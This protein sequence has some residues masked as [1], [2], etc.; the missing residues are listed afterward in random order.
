MFNLLKRFARF[1]ASLG[2]S[3]QIP[4]V[5]TDSY[6]ALLTTTL[7]NMQPRLHDN[8]TKG[9]KLIAWLEM[10]GRTRRVD[11]GERIQ[12]ALMHAQNS[13]ADIYSAYGTL[14]TTPQDG[15][16]AA[17]YEWAQLAVAISISRKEERQNSGQSRLLS[18][19]QSKTMQAEVSLKQLLNNCVVSG[20]I[21]S[22]VSGAS[23]RFSQRTG[24]LD[25]GALGPLPLPALVDVSPTRNVAIGN[26]NPSTYGFW[27]NQAVSSTATTFAGMKQEMNQTYNNASRGGGEGGGTGSPDLLIGD[28]RAWEQYWNSLQNQE[29]YIVDNPRVLNVLGGSEALKFR[30]GTFIWDE[31]VPD[32]ETNADLVDGIGTVTASTIYFLNTDNWEYIVDS[33]TDFITTP[34]ITPVGQ[35]ARVAEILWMGATAV[36]NRRK[37][38]VL[39]GISRSIVA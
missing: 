8:I 16:T 31:V 17:F 35:D 12:V 13:T 6:D 7:R 24:R 1:Y 29:R 21:T 28:Q 10:N 33:Q 9:N 2:Q 30:G 27:A 23:G 38:A 37:Q 4:S 3:G 25:S 11:G 39:Y 14:D 34:F 15:I 5:L 19:L 36:N 18:L 20:K 22:G 26:I 32:P